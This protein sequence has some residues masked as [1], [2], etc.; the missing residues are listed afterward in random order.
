[1]CE[2]VSHTYQLL[3]ALLIGMAIGLCIEFVRVMFD[4]IRDPDW[5]EAKY[6]NIADEA[7]SL[8][9]RAGK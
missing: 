7:R 1:M 2:K 4:A 9:K 5:F 8:R 6:R 3:I